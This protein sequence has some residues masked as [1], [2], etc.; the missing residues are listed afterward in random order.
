MGIF[1]RSSHDLAWLEDELRANAAL[2]SRGLVERTLG[3]VGPVRTTQRSSLGAR[4]MIALA[5][6]VVA[7]TSLGLLGGFSYVAHAANS[8]T[9]TAATA[10]GAKTVQ[11][12]STISIC[13]ATG[14][15]SNPYIQETVS[16]HSLDGATGPNDLVPAPA[17][18]C[19]ASRGS[20]TSFN[21]SQSSGDG[22]DNKGGGTSSNGGSGD[23]GGASSGDDGK[24]GCDGSAD[25]SDASGD[26][27]GHDDGGGDDQCGGGS[28]DDQYG[29][30]TPICH[31][32]HST[33]NPWVLIVVSSSA[34]PA[35]AAHG[36]IIPAPA[37]GCPAS[38]AGGGR[39]TSTDFS[40]DPAAH[41]VGDQIS[42]AIHVTAD[43]G[44]APLGT[45]TCY[46]GSRQFD[47]TPLV[48]GLGRCTE[49]ITS[50]GP[51]TIKVV[52][53]P[54][55]QTQ[56]SSSVSREVTVDVAKTTPATTVVSNASPSSP[57]AAVTFTATVAGPSSSATP[58]IGNVQFFDGTLPLG[59]AVTLV[60]GTA[61]IT[62][63]ALAPGSHA[64]TF[65]Y[66]GDSI[67]GTAT[68]SAVTQVVRSPSRVA[69]S[70]ISLTTSDPSP[71][72]GTS[73]TFT[74]TVSPQAPATGTPTGSVRFLDGTTPIATRT[75]ASGVA[76]FSMTTLSAGPHSVTAIYSGDASFDATTSPA[77]SVV[78][79][80]VATATA[81]SVSPENPNVKKSVTITARVTA[82][83][84]RVTAGAVTFS[85]FGRTIGT[86]AV[87]G[88]GEASV[89][90]VAPS[91]GTFQ[92]TG[93][94][95]PVSG[96]SYQAS[97]GSFSITVRSG[98]GGGGDG[99]GG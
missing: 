7:A 93:S 29:Q 76:T 43:G 26:G 99:G 79:G 86:S 16:K 63:S 53:T 45:A 25:Q 9:R 20:L 40:V 46:D 11:P 33:S 83:G 74:A 56:F 8:V 18:G 41:E 57:G 97:T 14:S 96:S 58:P 77:V 42:Y 24:G 27:N 94:Y 17:G 3:M 62:T 70:Q 50:G 81:L 52:F 82:G 72:V 13:R 38:P 19:P 66:A 10:L 35:H 54:V 73:V 59:A 90:V 6:A 71:A 44:G 21:S 67:Y 2:P 4:R 55:D 95:A 23:G 60:S 32:T 1:R 34:L 15:Q 80:Q 30:G 48:L 36:D 75:L 64:I 39:T 85:A 92:L 68:S 89:S 78:V 88:D 61:T 91:S 49:T 47:S 65:V 51:H 22:K 31:R 28:G 69:P 87:N 37:S 5:F 84:S 12:S 98:D